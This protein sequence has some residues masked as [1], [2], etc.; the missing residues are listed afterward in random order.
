[1]SAPLTG[2]AGGAAWSDGPRT[3]R[4][5]CGKPG[6]VI[7]GPG[8]G[9]AGGSV[10]GGT[11]SVGET[12]SVGGASV[13]GGTTGSVG[14]GSVDG[15]SVGGGTTGSVDG[16]SAGG[17]TTGSVEGVSAGGG[18]TGSG[19]TG[20]V[21][22][23]SVGGGKPGSVGGT[24][25][26]DGT[27]SLGPD[28]ASVEGDV[29]SGAGASSSTGTTAPAAGSFVA[30]GIPASGVWVTAWARPV[31]ASTSARM[32]AAAKRTSP[33]HS[34]RPEPAASAP[35]MV[36]RLGVRFLRPRKFELYGRTTIT[37]AAL[38]VRAGRGSPHRPTKY[39]SLRLRSRSANEPP[40]RRR[41][42]GSPSVPAPSR[43][44]WACRA[45]YS[46]TPPCRAASSSA[47]GSRRGFRTRTRS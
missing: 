5:S 35:P 18:T 11:E 40:P 8:S 19:G 15:V 21:D 45:R 14:T 38:A 29:P 41:S 9:T 33:T 31:A 37:A 30:A 23:V 22:G 28:P 43:R 13:G 24:G 47:A 16:G 25:S 36:R 20:S 17:G 27:G 4:G 3:P 7:G 46:G 42:R 32:N 12:G 1:V 26:V 10:G 6:W 34:R 44:R 39:L 2:T